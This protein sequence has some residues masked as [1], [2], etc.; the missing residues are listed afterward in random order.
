MK[1]VRKNIAKTAKKYADAKSTEWDDN[2]DVAKCNIFTQDVP[3]KVLTS[4][5]PKNP[6]TN[7]Y[8]LAQQLADPNVKIINWPVITDG[9]IE[10]GDIGA[11]QVN[12]PNGSYW[13]SGILQDYNSVFKLIYAGGSNGYISAS[14]I[15]YFISTTNKPWTIRRYT[16]KN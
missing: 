2:P 8:Y 6:L 1:E 10:I 5:F 15:K 3:N 13:H 11:G 14:P 12:T 4:S 16:P 9:S 7:D